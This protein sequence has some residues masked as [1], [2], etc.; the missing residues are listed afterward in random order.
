[1]VLDTRSRLLETR[2][3]IWSDTR[4][5]S[6]LEEENQSVLDTRK[7]DT[8]P[9]PSKYSRVPNKRTAV[10]QVSSSNFPLCTALLGSLYGRCQRRKL[11]F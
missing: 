7:I 11:F 2:S 4:L 1:M 8:R 3:K 9:T 10:R 5:G 6:M